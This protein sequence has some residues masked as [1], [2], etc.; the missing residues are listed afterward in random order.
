MYKCLECGFE[1]DEPNP[2]TESYG[3]TFYYCPHCGSAEYHDIEWFKCEACGA[4]M[5]N[6]DECYCDNCKQEIWIAVTDGISNISSGTGLTLGSAWDAYKEAIDTIFENEAVLGMVLNSIM[7][8]A[9]ACNC[10]CSTAITMISE[11]ANGDMT[12][13][14]NNREER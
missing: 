8:L 13:R 3:Q 14:P 6:M 11:Y 12:I 1:F 4:V 5:D 7:A 9:E 2:E 10:K